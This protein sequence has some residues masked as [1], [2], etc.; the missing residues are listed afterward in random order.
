MAYTL[1][2]DN[3]LRMRLACTTASQASINTFHWHVNGIEGASVSDTDAAVKLDQLLAGPMKDLLSDDATYYGLSLQRILPLPLSAPAIN[4]TGTGQGAEVDD[5]IPGQVTGII[6]MQTAFAGARYRGRMYIPFPARSFSTDGFPNTT[7]RDLLIALADELDSPITV[8]TLPNV[9][10][11]NPVIWHRATGTWTP[12]TTVIHR[13]RW[14][15][16]RKRGDYGQRNAA[17]F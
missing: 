15:T 9:A 7:Y 14:A 1:S 12:I 17:P 4:R 3:I 5:M 6:S 10:V 8:G 13:M 16:Q 11:L 2:A